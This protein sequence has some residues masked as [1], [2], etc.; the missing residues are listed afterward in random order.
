ME[1]G[2]LRVAATFLRLWWAA[3]VAGLWHYPGGIS[4]MVGHPRVVG[5]ALGN[6]DNNW[7]LPKTRNLLP[8]G[9]KRLDKQS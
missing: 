5:V 6:T 7:F 1:D 3:S 4:G 8:I 9:I 2:S